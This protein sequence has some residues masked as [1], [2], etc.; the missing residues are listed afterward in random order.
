MARAQRLIPTTEIIK[1]I[2]KTVIAIMLPTMQ[3]AQPS[4]VCTYVCVCVC[5]CVC[6]HVCVCVRACMCVV[7]VCGMCVCVCVCVWQQN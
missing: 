2:T 7:C 4:D 5:V 3:P 6:V 1:Q